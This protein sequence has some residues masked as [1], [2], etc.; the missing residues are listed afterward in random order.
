M[1]LKFQAGLNIADCFS[2]RGAAMT[3][4]KKNL[5]MGHL[6]ISLRNA[7]YEKYMA[8]DLNIFG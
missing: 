4:V 2:L 3:F 5:L 6:R 8:P 1:L 7:L